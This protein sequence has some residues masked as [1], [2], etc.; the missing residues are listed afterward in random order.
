MRKSRSTRSFSRPPQAPRRPRAPR[1]VSPLEAQLGYWLL[2]ATHPVAVALGRQLESA[3]VTITEWFVLREL[4]DGARRPSALADKLGLTR[5]SISK[6]TAKLLSGRMVTL[7]AGIDGDGRGRMLALS[8]FGRSIVPILAVRMEANEQAL[9]A[10]LDPEARGM[11]VA[12]LRGI[13]HRRDLPA[14]PMDD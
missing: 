4:Y 14:V 8:A 9:F 10:D 5:G 3:G 6:L 13:T 1:G 2:R 12:A 11:L 7:E